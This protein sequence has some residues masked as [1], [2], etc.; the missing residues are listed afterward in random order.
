M[1]VRNQSVAT[2]ALGHQFEFHVHPDDELL[3]N[4]V[5][6]KNAYS[7]GDV[8]VFKKFLKPGDVFIDVGA[9]I[10]WYSVVASLVLGETGKILAIEPEPRNLELLRKNLAGVKTPYEIHAAAVSD[11][12]GTAELYLSPDNFGDHSLVLDG[13]KH[14][15]RQKVSVP[16]ERLESLITAEDFKKTGLLKM[17]IQ[18]SEP[19]ALVGMS[20]LLRLHRP[21]MFIE[22]SPSHIYECGSSPFEIFAFIEK[23]K[24]FP[25]QVFDGASSPDEVLRPISLDSLF[26]LTKELRTANYGID[27]VLATEPTLDR[28][29]N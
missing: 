19:K 26:A 9:N 12:K 25:F 1:P 22:F 15:S 27:L 23:W 16:L 13:F 14:V 3:S 28:Q 2:S 7:T 17:D 11:E 8:A 6:G 29:W 21:V 10:G 5:R 4:I 18:G 24:Y 20:S